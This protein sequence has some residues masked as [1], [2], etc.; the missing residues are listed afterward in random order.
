MRGNAQAINLILIVVFIA[1]I[2]FLMIRPQKKRDKETKAMRD[3]LKPGDE[4]LTIGGIKGKIV[5]IKEDTVTIAVGADKV[6]LE[7]VKSA[8][9]TVLD[10][11][12]DNAEPKK[13]KSQKAITEEEDNTPKPDRNKKVRPKKLNKDEKEDKEIKKEAKKEVKKEIKKEEPKK[14]SKEEK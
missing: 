13:E 3:A 4:I 1:V 12:A 11:K 6:K 2:Y 5:R 8:I 7:F 14:E 10:K 9:A